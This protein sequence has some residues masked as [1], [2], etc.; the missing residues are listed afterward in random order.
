MENMIC[1]NT[2]GKGNSSHSQKGHKLATNIVLFKFASL[3]FF[4]LVLFVLFF[5]ADFTNFYKYD[6]ILEFLHV[7]FIICMLYFFLKSIY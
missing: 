4:F 6:V 1:G 5:V 2:N 3:K 7:F